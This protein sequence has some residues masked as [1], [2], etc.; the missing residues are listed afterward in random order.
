MPRYTNGLNPI[1]RQL[2]RATTGK[3]S[4][5]SASLIPRSGEYTPHLAKISPQA[6]L[7]RG[8]A[9]TAATTEDSF[10]LETAHGSCT[11]AP[12]GTTRG[13]SLPLSG[14]KSF[15]TAS[16]TAFPS[17]SFSKPIYPA[18]P[19]LRRSSS[20]RNL[21]LTLTSL[22]STDQSQQKPCICSA[23]AERRSMTP[24]VP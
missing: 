16:S 21:F 7:S 24:K 15:S 22:S 18:N 12:T 14:I 9:S 4:L 20:S 13:T 11:I 1:Q 6:S 3:G 19:I 5:A 10:P 17:A 8:K 2:D 23:V